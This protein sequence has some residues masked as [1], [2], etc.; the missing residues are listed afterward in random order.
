MKICKDCKHFNVHPMLHLCRHPK[1][2][3]NLVNGY[4]NLE[5]AKDMRY[6]YEDR[7]SCGTEGNWWEPKPPKPTKTFWAKIFG[8]E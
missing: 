6:D 4:N 3:I 7:I 1:L 8:V 2:G 5:S